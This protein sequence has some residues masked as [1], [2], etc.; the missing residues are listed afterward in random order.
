MKVISRRWCEEVTGRNGGVADI[1]SL[2]TLDG[3]GRSCERE[4]CEPKDRDTDSEE[5]HCDGN[6]RVQMVD[7]EVEL[8]KCM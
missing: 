1:E 5:L 6:K 4:C 2:E 3:K 8:I 7:D